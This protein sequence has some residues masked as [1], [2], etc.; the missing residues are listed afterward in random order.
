MF[1]YKRRLHFYETDSM[2]IIHHANYVHVL[3]E[4]RVH[5]I[6]QFGDVGNREL[7]GDINYPVLQCH[8]DYKNP[9][10]FDDEVSVQVEASAKGVRL[11]FDYVLTTERFEKPVAFGKTVHAAFDMK[12]RKPTKIP[13]AVLEFL[14][15]K[16]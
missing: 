1:T 7:L 10:Y 13:K 12:A 15:E 14:A 8:I 2:G 11:T 16:G 6:R 3:E 9:L 5:W 4:A